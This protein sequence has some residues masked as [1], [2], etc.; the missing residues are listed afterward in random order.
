MVSFQKIRVNLKQ[1]YVYIDFFIT[2]FDKTTVEAVS[3]FEK[4]F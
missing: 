2:E 4:D 1:F 3:I